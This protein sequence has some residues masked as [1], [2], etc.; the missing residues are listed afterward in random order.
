M[1]GQLGAPWIRTDPGDRFRNRLRHRLP[2]L[3]AG[4]AERGF[5]PPAAG[6]RRPAERI[7]Q[8]LMLRAEGSRVREI[9]NGWGT[10]PFGCVFLDPGEQLL[11]RDRVENLVRP[12]ELRRL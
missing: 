12:F 8:A 10:G 9:L 6:S 3:L 7:D 4:V 2:R 11:R 5:P 1:S